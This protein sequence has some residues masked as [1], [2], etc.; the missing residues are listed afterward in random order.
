MF[1]QQEM[2]D[3]QLL[4]NYFHNSCNC[5]DSELCKTCKEEKAANRLLAKID[6]QKKSDEKPKRNIPYWAAKNMIY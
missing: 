1:T 4:I 6:K 2:K 5:N 3:I